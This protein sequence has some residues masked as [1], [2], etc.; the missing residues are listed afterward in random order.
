LCCVYV[1]AVGL[2]E[3]SPMLSSLSL[4]YR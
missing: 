1:M 3:L 2:P 4:G